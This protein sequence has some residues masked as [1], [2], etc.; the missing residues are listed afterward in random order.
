M[1]R[2]L[3]I[4]LLMTSI[5]FAAPVDAPFNLD[6]WKEKFTDYNAH[7]RPHIMLL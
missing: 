6:A 1:G 7:T 2:T 5:L 3:S 4:P